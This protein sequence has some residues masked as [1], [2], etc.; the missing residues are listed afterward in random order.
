MTATRELRL[1]CDDPRPAEVTTGMNVLSKRDF[2]MRP[3]PK[4]DV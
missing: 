3:E 4:S 1:Y 2:I